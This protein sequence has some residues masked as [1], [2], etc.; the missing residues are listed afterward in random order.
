MHGLTTNRHECGVSAMLTDSDLSIP[1][2]LRHFK[3]LPRRNA[4]CK[5]T[6]TAFGVLFVL[7]LAGPPDGHAESARQR[8]VATIVFTD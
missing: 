7:T 4:G 8:S 3:G 2:R 5:T 1:L 6:S